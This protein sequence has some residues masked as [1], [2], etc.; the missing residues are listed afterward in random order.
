MRTREEQIRVANTILQQ[1]GGGRFRTMTGARDVFA[2]DAG[3][4][5]KV[6]GT[7]TKKHINYIRITL[8]PTD[9]YT[10]EFW[11]YRA[12]QGKKISEHSMVY[13]DMLQNIF[14]Q[15]TGLDTHL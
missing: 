5:F 7:L 1:L 11:T 10:M 4:T 9:T 8:D 15:E 13:D 12:M 2:D 3:L 14:T 6:P